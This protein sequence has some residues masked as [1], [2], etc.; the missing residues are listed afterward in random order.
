CMAPV[1]QD[2]AVVSVR[3]S[4]WYWPGD[5]IAYVNACNQLRVHRVIGYLPGRSGLRLI[6]QADTC[7]APDSPVSFG[8][9]IGKTGPVPAWRRVQATGRFLRLACRWLCRR[10]S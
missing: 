3:A 8:S 1:L 7:E 6:T 5:V 9:V 2:G 4:R 10:I